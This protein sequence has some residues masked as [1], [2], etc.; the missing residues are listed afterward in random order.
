MFRFEACKCLDEVHWCKCRR[1]LDCPKSLTPHSEL[2]LRNCLEYTFY[3][4]KMK[5][6]LPSTKPTKEQR[7]KKG[8]CLNHLKTMTSWVVNLLASLRSF[9]P[10]LHLIPIMFFLLFWSYTSLW[11]SK[12]ILSQITQYNFDKDL[13]KVLVNIRNVK[14]NIKTKL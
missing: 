5:E 6:E 7:R 3:I 8:K 12:L 4:P 1:Y 11:E 2:K 9:K 14:G 13:L 10:A